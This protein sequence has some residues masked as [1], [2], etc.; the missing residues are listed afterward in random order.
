MQYTGEG[1]YAEGSECH[2]GLERKSRKITYHDT[3]RLVAGVAEESE[4]ELNQARHSREASWLV[5]KLLETMIERIYGRREISGCDLRSR[6]E[7]KAFMS[8][9]VNSWNS[10]SGLGS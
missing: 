7:G 8:M 10:K 2:K 6:R 1:H 4:D 3:N 9:Y 5:T